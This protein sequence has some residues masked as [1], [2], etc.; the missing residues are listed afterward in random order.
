[1]CMGGRGSLPVVPVLQLVHV[2]L[3]D[4]HVL[5]LPGG[6]VVGQVL[7]FDEV[8]DIVLLVQAEG[9]TDRKLTEPS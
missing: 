5:C 3:W 6:L 8:M 1:M 2:E 7:P 4:V 9:N